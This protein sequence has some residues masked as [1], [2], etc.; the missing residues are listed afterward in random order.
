VQGAQ[1]EQDGLQRINGAH[2]VRPFLFGNL[3]NGYLAGACW[4]C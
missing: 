3:S 2:K 4:R 1:T